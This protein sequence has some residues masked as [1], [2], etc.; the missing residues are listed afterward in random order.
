MKRLQV[1]LR[2]GPADGRA[3]G[4]CIFSHCH[5]HVGKS[6]FTQSSTKPDNPTASWTDYILPPPINTT[7]N[8]LNKLA[9]IVV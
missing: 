4:L 3:G 7:A 5:Y 9:Q 1:N 6:D 8:A 2:F